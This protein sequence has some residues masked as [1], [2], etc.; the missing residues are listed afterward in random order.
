M[1]ETAIDLRI[2]GHSLP[3]TTCL[4]RQGVQL[5][6]QCNAGIVDLVPGDSASATFS[7]RVVRVS[8]ESGTDFKGPCVHGKRGD[9]FLYLCWVERSEP[10]HHEMF[11]RAKLLLND[12]D[13]SLID[14]ASSSDRKLTA[15]LPSRTAGGTRRADRF[16]RR[17]C[18][19]RWKSEP[20]WNEA[21]RSRV[22][23]AS[24]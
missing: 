15:T 9:R 8:R 21:K 17:R 6:V 20:R 11:A 16:A 5:G 1:P 10:N 19:G 4:G 23:A 7:V 18:S 3:G 2:V 22:W 12:I 13:A 14:A 24:V